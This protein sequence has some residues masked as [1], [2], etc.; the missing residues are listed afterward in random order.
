M[1]AVTSYADARMIRAMPRG[2]DLQRFVDA[3]EQGAA[4]ERAFADLQAGQ[5]RG[6]WMW[7]VMPQ[8]AGLQD[9]E[10]SIYYSIPDIDTA[11]QYLEHPLLGSRL[12]ECTQTLTAWRHRSACEVFG[13]VD[14]EKLHQSITLFARVSSDPAFQTIL[15]QW[16]DGRGDQLT[17]KLL[18]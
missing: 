1:S 8:L 13:P 16:F 18:A 3:Q 14:A 9:S 11:R 15:K 17:D 4:Y 6:C 12:L 10:R 2:F 7:F 5:K